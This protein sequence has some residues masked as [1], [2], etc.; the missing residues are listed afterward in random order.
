MS[1]GQDT[2]GNKF[3]QRNSVYGMDD[4]EELNID[5]Q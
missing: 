3:G 1:I 2:Q 4:E 5:D